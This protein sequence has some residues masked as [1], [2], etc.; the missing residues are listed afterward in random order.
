MRGRKEDEEPSQDELG[1]ATRGEGRLLP[2]EN[3]PVISVGAFVGEDR[4]ER[5]KLGK[6]FYCVG[7]AR[8]FRSPYSVAVHIKTC[9]T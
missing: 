2:A 5:C 6:V 4:R 9:S 3:T 1:Q 7:K 8:V